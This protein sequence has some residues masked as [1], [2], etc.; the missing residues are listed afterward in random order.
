MLE[1]S[2]NLAVRLSAPLRYIRS[3][4]AYLSD[5]LSNTFSVTNK[6]LPMRME[7]VDF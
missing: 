6:V 1:K 5:L 3:S 2:K 4:L 7:G